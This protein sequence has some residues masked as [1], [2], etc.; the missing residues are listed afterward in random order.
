MS[1]TTNHTFHLLPVTA[2]V[3]VMCSAAWAQTASDTKDLVSP[4]TSSITLG[5]GWVNSTRDAL[6][7]GQ[8]TGYNNDASPIIDL[9]M[10]RRDEALGTLTTL[11]GRDL[12]LDTRE[13]LYSRERQGDW[14]FALDYNEIVRNDPS[15]INTG[16]TGVGT[17]KPTVNLIQLPAM[18]NAWATANGVS[19]NSVAGSEVQLKLKRTAVGLSGAKWISPDL[20]LEVALK[21]ETKTGARLFGRAGLDSGEMALRPKS[22]GS[23]SANGGWAVLLAPE[24]VN[25]SIQQVE[26]KLNFNRGNLAM[27]GGYAGSFYTNSNGSLT[28]NVPGTLNRG[29]LWNVCATAGCSTVQAL[30][31]SDVALPPDNQ[32]HQVY[33]DGTY[34]FSP[35]TRANFKLSYTHATQDENFVSMGLT[36][37]ATAPASL[38][39]VVDT[40]LA[41]VGLTARPIKDL[42]VNASLRLEDRNDSTPVYVY[43]YG[44]ASTA[45]DKTTNWPS[46][47]QKRTTAKVDGAYRLGNGYTATTGLDWERKTTPLPTANTAL[48]AK[49]V[50]F[51]EVLTETGVHAGLRKAFSET[52]N[53]AVSLGYQQK[54]GDDNGWFTTSSTKAPDTNPLVAFNPGSAAFN[55]TSTG[56]AC[57][58]GSIVSATAC[59]TTANIV[60]PDMYMDRNQTK[61]RG[62]LDW[63]PSEKLSLQTV[64]EHKQDEYLRAWP[65]TVMFAGYATSIIPGARTISNDSLTLDASYQLTSNWQ[66]SSYLTH[67]QNRWN[68]NKANVGDDTVNKSDTLGVNVSG[69]LTNHFS[70]GAGLVWANDVTTFNNVVAVGTATPAGNIVVAG[71]PLPGNF[72]PDINYKTTKLNLFGR[73]DFDKQ[74]S[75]LMSLVHQKFENDD[76]Q[77][78]YNGVPFL[79]SDNTT[80]SNPNQ[81]V[82][83]V[84][85]SYNYKF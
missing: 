55:L 56:A 1:H 9:E 75:V 6:R 72:L 43:N 2:A 4:D 40:T 74:S 11:T 23:A 32:A 62:N 35:T 15:I 7:F 36:P 51:R 81:S 68:V 61:I 67:S 73:Y 45:L 26:T 76:W 29:A 38:G 63:E 84:G 78:G 19:G 52:L 70:V 30:A 71:Q 21:N 44:A 8:Y 79:Y 50:F 57:T 37:A 33:V 82:T 22:G 59:S 46:G 18:P 83:F 66:L 48:F 3:M 14:K 24:P 60:L 64:L 13:L 25:S 12:G 54:K 69:K 47:S 41:Q 85:V 10:I 20:Q 77:W 27:T 49:Q 53:G 39:G 16:M 17:T 31:S 34:G 58:Q 80:V 28:L 5:A 42:S 65:A